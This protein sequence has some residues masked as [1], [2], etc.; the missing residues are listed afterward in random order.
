M[1]APLI[2]RIESKQGATPVNAYLLE[3]PNVVV[4][5]DATLT[6]GGGGVLRE[7]ADALAKSL[8]G[9]V[10]TLVHPDH[11]GGLVA[12]PDVPI[13]STQ[14]VHDIVRRDDSVKEQILRPMFGDDWPRERVFPSRVVADGETVD[15]GDFGL[16]VRDLGPSESPADS[17]WALADDPR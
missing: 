16:T 6:V 15:F 8:V 11:Y 13:Y 9:A 3:G 12:L 1:A 14:A 5:V 7:R 17:I 2:H 4:A 10:L